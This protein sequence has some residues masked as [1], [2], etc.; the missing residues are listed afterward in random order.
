VV[1]PLILLSVLGLATEAEA[2]GRQFTFTYESSVL[3]QWGTE[4]ELWSTWRVKRASYYSRFDERLEFELGLTD[5]LQTALYLNARSVTAPSAGALKTEFKFQGLSSEWKYKLL[6]P[7]A[8]PVGMAI[9]GEVS[10]GPD[11]IEFEAKFIV[12][13]RFGAFLLAANVV[14]EY[15]LKFGLTENEFEVVFEA[16]LGFAWFI[17]EN[18]TLGIEVRNHNLVTAGGFQHSALFAGPTLA[19]AGKKWW[20]ALSFMP[21]LPAIKASGDATLVLDEFERFN[22][23]L[24]FGVHL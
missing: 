10:G 8:D 11:E 20:V 5:R 23:R 13:K 6:D 17:T 24:L 21:Q 16:D 9:Y 4:L 2:S 3:P 1:A 19:V 14:A 22:T 15:E 7:V 18:V 12:D